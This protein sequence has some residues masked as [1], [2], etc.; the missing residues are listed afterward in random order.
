[1]AVMRTRFT[2]AI[3]AALALAGM[4]RPAFASSLVPPAGYYSEVRTSNKAAP[5]CAAAPPAFTGTLD[6]PSKYEGS[7]KSRDSLNDESDE[8][9]KALTQPISD[10]EKGASRLVDRYMDGGSAQA[11]ACVL[12][13]YGGW[14]SA[15]ALLGPAADHTGRSER[16]WALASLSGAWLRLKFSRSQPLAAH[17]KEAAM[18]ES[19][20]GMI[21][22]QVTREWNEDDPREKINNHYYW[23]AW[24]VMATSVITDRRDLFDWSTRM[25]VIFAQQVD[26][27]G[28]LPNELKRQ[29]R[30]AG[31]QIYAVTPAVMLAA[32]G[33]ANHVDLAGQ[34]NNALQRAAQRAMAAYADPSSF[35]KKTGSAQ[36][37]DDPKAQSARMAWLEPYCWALVC[38]GSEQGTLRKLRPMQNTRLGGDVTAVF[39][40]Q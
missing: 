22:D 8:R 24:S 28:F 9:Y 5:A 2:A 25:Y 38:S 40:A 34:G 36:V 10:M 35:E 3:G 7:G 32:F 12:S 26:G 30:A 27:E 37:S 1:M 39:S 15:H 31:Y 13:W 18:I 20:L 33:K 23:A 21:A 14:A 17:A 29:T 6:F 19:W 16:K 4:A 11:L